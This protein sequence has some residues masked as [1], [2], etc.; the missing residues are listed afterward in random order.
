MTHDWDDSYA[1]GMQGETFLDN[2][3][4]KKFRIE[5]VSRDEQRQGID[6]YFTGVTGNR[7]GVEYKTDSRAASTGNAFVETVSV[8]TAGKA[9]WVYKSKSKY[10][11][12]YLPTVGII[13]CIKLSVIRE[14][15]AR[16]TRQYPTRPAHNRDYNTY[17]ILVPLH[18]FKTL[19]EWIISC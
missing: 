5:Q 17:G 12:Y 13:Y 10:L 9:G 11:V 2:L 19:A 18:E 15:L 6:R 3:F 7:F 1:A 4:S 16:W 14:H 8:D